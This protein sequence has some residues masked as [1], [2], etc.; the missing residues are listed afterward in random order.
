MKVKV[1]YGA[2]PETVTDLLMKI[3]LSHPKGIREPGPSVIFQGFGDNSLDFQLLFWVPEARLHVAVNSEVA[4]K[5]AHEFRE[6]GINLPA[7][8]REVHITGIDTSVK[9]LLDVSEG[10][11]N[12]RPP[13]APV[14]RSEAAHERK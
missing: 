12:V 14:I 7:Q 10:K 11:Q 6:A 9:E 4:M 3:A 5:V 13:D 2:D 8:K 1:A